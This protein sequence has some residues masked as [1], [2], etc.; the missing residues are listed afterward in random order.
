MIVIEDMEEDVNSVEVMQCEN[1]K[2]P[3]GPTMFRGAINAILKYKRAIA[4]DEDDKPVAILKYKSSCYIHRYKYTGVVDMWFLNQYDCLFLHDCNEYSVELCQSVL[5]LWNGRRLVLVGKNWKRMIPLLLDLTNIECFYEETLS[6]ERFTELTNG[7]RFL[8][9]IYG[10]P[11]EES[12]DRYND[13]IMYYDEV[14][15]FIFLFS[16]YRELGEKNAEKKF[17]VM[18]G[19]YS[20]IG[21]FAI[22]S[23]IEACVRYAKSKGFIPVIR[24]EMS[25]GSYYSDFKGDDIWKKFY[26]QPEGYSLEEVMQS[27]HVFF[28]PG[29]Y[30]GSIQSN[31]MNQFS[32]HTSLSWPEGIYNKRVCECINARQKQFLPC[33][34]RTLG[35]LARGTDYVNTHLSNHPIHATISMLCEK[36]DRALKEWNLEYIYVATEDESY[37]RYLK[38]RYG[39]R[40]SFTNQKRYSVRD[41]EMLSQMHARQKEKRNG[42]LLGAEYILAIKL[43]SQCNSLLA[44]GYCG[45]VYEA[46]KEN[47]GT[48]QNIYVFELGVNS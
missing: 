19:I 31:I 3:Y 9:V 35:V 28:C 47:M 44:S 32:E 1:M 37:C 40:V 42:Y 43:L 10:V 18:D 22:F 15:S 5:N 12:M 17:F 14:M 45:G 27:K 48:Y 16:D 4:V 2:V 25:S 13:G 36:I 6:D 30:N 26:N 39:K 20:S 24:L 33:P 46:I 7:M 8:N 38:E 41:G 34:E 23:K 29:L 21:L 11:H